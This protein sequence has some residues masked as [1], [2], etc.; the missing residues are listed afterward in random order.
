MSK[1]VTK[2]D[3]Q[4]VLKA[5]E[6]TFKPWIEAG[7]HGPQLVENYE[8]SD[9]MQVHPTPWAIVWEDGSPYEWA[10]NFPH[11]GVDEEFGFKIKAAELPKSVHTEPIFSFVLGIFEGF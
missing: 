3:A 5:V 4:R 1:R 2:T 8:W 6:T 10:Y 7:M 9:G 11:G